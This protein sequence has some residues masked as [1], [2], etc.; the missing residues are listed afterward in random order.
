MNV[1]NIEFI[2]TNGPNNT[3]VCINN[4]AE[5]NCGFTGANY[6][7]IFPDWIVINRSDNGS[8]LSNF[9]Y[10]NND[11]QMGRIGG[12]K[13]VPGNGS[14]NN[15]S[16]NSKLS[17]GPVNKT[18][19]QSSYQCSFREFSERSTVGTITVVGKMTN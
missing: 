18:H 11:V 7:H 8:I 6:I 10:N 13:W 1:H 14:T 15:N 16:S 4:T 19:D 12:L 9:T 3:T 17:V 5:I 2:I